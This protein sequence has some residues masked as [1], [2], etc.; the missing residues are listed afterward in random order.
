MKPGPDSRIKMWHLTEA[1]LQVRAET[2]DLPPGICGRVSG[3]AL[4][5]EVVDTYDT[6]FARGCAKR[7]VDTRVAARKVPLLMD[8]DRSVKSHIGVV[9]AM[10]EVGDALLMTADILDT[11]EGRESL[12]YVKAVIAAGASTGFSIGFIPRRSEWVKVGDR[13]CERF[14]E[15]ELREVSVTPMP[16]V[17]GADV[18]G[19]RAED[20]EPEPMRSDAEILELAAR[21]ALDAMPADT[22]AT[23][24][25]QYLAVT[26]D[27][28]LAP[29]PATP[30]DTPASERAATMDERIRAVRQSYH[31]SR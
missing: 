4:T 28:R 9:A 27:A 25:S 20:G 23:L 19:A 2:P 1:A 17:P 7:S 30:I 10:E 11:D 24:L 12:A 22:R 14:T 31:I 18:L 15:I 6:I 26:H 29:A 21:L 3:I 16:A 8:H 13:S 5:Y